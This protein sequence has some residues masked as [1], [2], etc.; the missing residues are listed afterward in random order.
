[1]EMRTHL[2]QG[3]MGPL[4]IGLK[5]L[6]VLLGQGVGHRTSSQPSCN[7]RASVFEPRPE[8]LDGAPGIRSVTGPYVQ[9]LLQGPTSPVGDIVA[10]TARRA[11]G[12][13]MIPLPERPAEQAGPL[14]LQL[15]KVPDDAYV[16]TLILR[17]SRHRR[18]PFPALQQH[19]REHFS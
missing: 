3:L 8:E 19:R 9:A 13:A 2:A 12:V 5:R 16:L 10:S 4:H 6:S 14:L 17:R 18:P 7:S 1:M 11:R 15:K